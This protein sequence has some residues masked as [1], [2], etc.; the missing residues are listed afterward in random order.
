MSGP[1]SSDS[2]E[3]PATA[4][5]REAREIGLACAAGVENNL[6]VV[7]VVVVVVAAVGGG[8]DVGGGG[9]DLE[10][11]ARSGAGKT[12]S[13]DSYSSTPYWG[14]NSSAAGSGQA[15]KAAWNGFRI[16]LGL[17]LVLVS[18]LAGCAPRP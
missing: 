10:G 13:G 1:G 16:R 8:G 2:A 5:C 12:L 4:A 6:M 18:V 9:R 3:I 11:S 17:V 15:V 14:H 7:D